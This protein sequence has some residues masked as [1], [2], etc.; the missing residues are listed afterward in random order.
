MFGDNPLRKAEHQ[1]DGQRLTV[2]EHFLTIQGEGPHAGRAAVFIRLWGCNLACWYCDTDFE[3]N[4]ETMSVEKILTAVRGYTDGN[5]VALVVLS[6][7]EPMRQNIV[8]L[9]EAL[10]F[11]G[12]TVQIE[13]NGIYWLDGLMPLITSRKVD[14]VVSPKT[15]KI[16]PMIAEHALAWKYIVKE[17]EVC[18]VD[19]LPFV[20]TQKKK[21]DL[22][23]A[24]PPLTVPPSYVYI[25]PCDEYD[26]ERTRPNELTAIHS[27]MNYGYRFSYQVHKAIQLP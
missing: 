23:L 5:Q 13:T 21:R 10:A 4:R 2:Q 27:A 22:K 26:V 24:R 14:I 17:G 3:S 19:G 20:S 1:K 16:H 7:G 12:F 25:Q 8:P 11:E 15:G 18:P 6:G 9:C